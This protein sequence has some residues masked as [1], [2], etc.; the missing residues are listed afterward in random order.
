M[1]SLITNKTCFSM[2]FVHIRRHIGESG[3]LRNSFD[4]SQTKHVSENVV[5]LLNVAIHFVKVNHKS[6]NSKLELY[7]IFGSCV[8]IKILYELYYNMRVSKRNR[9]KNVF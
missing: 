2:K 4:L 8:T 9:R 7:Y 1:F 5:S 6:C 3:T